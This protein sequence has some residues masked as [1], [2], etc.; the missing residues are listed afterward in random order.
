M[1]VM[2]KIVSGILWCTLII[3]ILAI[4]VLLAL[5]LYFFPDYKPQSPF[6]LVDVNDVNNV[7]DMPSPHDRIKPAQIKVYDDKIVL[8]IKKSFLVSFA[9]TK[10]MDPVLDVEANAIEIKPESPEDIF[11]GDIIAY[12]NGDE[13][14]VHR[15]IEVGYDENGWFAITK[16]DNNPV[17]DKTKVRFENVRGIVI[18]LVY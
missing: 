8:E 1:A 3:L 16:G 7:N 15:V 14:I 11:V 10:S 6:S 13:V 12:Q 2:T 9:P 4:F 17:N 18:A 5:L